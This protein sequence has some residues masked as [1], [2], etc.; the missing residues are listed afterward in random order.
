ETYEFR[1][2]DFVFRGHVV[3]SAEAQRGRL[4]TD[5]VRWKFPVASARVKAY[6][7]K[8]CDDFFKDHEGGLKRAI[9]DESEE[10]LLG[11][12]VNRIYQELKNSFR[13]DS[14]RAFEEDNGLASE[15]GLYRK[16]LRQF[17]EGRELTVPPAD[18][19][20][21][22]DRMA[23]LYIGTL[24]GTVPEQTGVSHVLIDEAQDYGPLHMAVM[25]RLFSRAVFTVLADVRQAFYP[26][27]AFTDP[28]EL[29]AFF[30]GAERCELRHSYRCTR[31][32]TAFAN[33]YIGEVPAEGQARSGDEPVLLRENPKT[34]IPRILGGLPG[35]TV[36]ILTRTGPE[37]AALHKALRGR[38]RLVRSP[39]DTFGGG[40]TVMPAYLSKGL[41]FDTAILVNCER[42][43]EPGNL[44]YTLCTRALH[45]LFII[46]GY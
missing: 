18:G 8:A 36:G 35:G 16:I 2:R 41:E 5:G 25:K 46:E 34:A 40:V 42:S 27:A 45:R 20:A 31:E 9:S 11:W 7:E 33:R 29:A 14:V 38:A 22:E 10:Q 32:I 17:C 44:M 21:Y 12:E 15:A 39:D 26:A 13:E 30:P 6:I 3:C 37:A 4:Y 1:L 23:L 43:G 19:T 24:T 28:E